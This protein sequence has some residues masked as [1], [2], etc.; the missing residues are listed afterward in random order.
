MI[1]ITSFLH[2]SMPFHYLGIP[3]AT[4]RLKI[5]NFSHLL[6]RFKNSIGAWNQRILP[7]TSRLQLIKSV[8][9]GVESFWLSILPIPS[10]IL[11]KVT[12]L[13]RG[14]LWGKSNPLVAWRKLALPF[15]EGGVGIRDLLTWNMTLLCKLL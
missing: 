15:D 14:F 13:C 5:V 9:Q 2:G 10:A 4:N 6:E 1:R 8:V 12:S 7:Y 11:G 3:I